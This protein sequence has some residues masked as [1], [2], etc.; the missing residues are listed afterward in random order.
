[1]APLLPAVAAA[2]AA[3]RD[4]GSPYPPGRWRL[5][6]PNALF[7]VLLRLSH[8]LIRHQAVQ[9]GIVSF[10]LPDWK[11]SA[12]PPARAPEQAREL[13]ERIAQRVQEHPEEFAAVAREASEDIA[14]RE[15]GGALGPRTAADFLRTPEI[16][17]AVAALHTGEVS[18]VI[19][20]QYGFHVI[21]REPPL[22]QETISASRILIAHDQAPWLG[23]FLARRSLPHRSREEALRIAQS[24][25][26]RALAGES[27]GALAREYSDHR[28]A[29]RD[30]DFG[31]WST[32]EATP[33]PR[34][35]ELLARMKIGEIQAPIDSPFGVAI[36]QRQPNRA[37]RAF[38]MSTVQQGFN[39]RA[40]DSDPNSRNW[41]MK[42][43]RALA[44]E[45][46]GEPGKFAD[47]QKQYCCA[48][49]ERWMEGRGEAE[50]EA[51]LL[52]LKPGAIASEPVDLAAALGIVR[53]LEPPPMPTPP[54]VFELPAPAQPDVSYLVSS[55]R[56]RVIL[57]GF[58]AEPAR[59]LALEP[60][61]E[62]RYIGLLS[63]LVDGEEVEQPE[64]APQFQR[65]QDQL[66]AL[67]GPERFQRHLDQLN[68]YMEATL[69]T[70]SPS[71][72]GR[73]LQ[74]MAVGDR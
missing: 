27:F 43:M 13:A 26:Q 9:E 2:Q 67:L 61:L 15:Q 48:H 39:P 57:R 31:A 12:P 36:L 44:R 29:L 64:R 38:A 55:G 25:Y 66:L 70:S 17:D 68:A 14:T 34:E 62:H 54:V 63:E 51:M 69:L 50:A 47:L 19:E 18:Q 56:M 10:Q 20:T 59:R 3:Q 11:P 37:R 72:R 8:I 58:V 7:P 60:E 73:I 4:T 52:K 49:E 6:S 45:I 24:L 46:G 5:A 41:V 65:V 74:G 1:M 33:Y 35:M 21:R 53:R 22:E 42:N 28:E 71:P 32:R 23:M 30:G 16:L 40:E